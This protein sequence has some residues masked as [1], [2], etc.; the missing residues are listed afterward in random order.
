MRK[1]AS[2]SRVQMTQVSR[3]AL[4]AAKRIN[5]QHRLILSGTPIQNNILELWALFDFLMPGFL[6]T[7][8]AFNARYGKALAAAKGSKTGSPEAQAGLLAMESLHKQARHLFK[9]NTSDGQR[10]PERPLRVGYRI[11]EESDGANDAA[12]AE[13]NQRQGAQ[14]IRA[15]RMP[16]FCVLCCLVTCMR[17][18]KL[19]RCKVHDDQGCRTSTSVKVILIVQVMPFVLR[20]T[21]DQVL[22]DLPPKIIQDVYVEP[23]A[24]QRQLYEDFSSTSASQQA[25]SAVSGDISA[26]SAASKAPHVF[27]V[28]AEKHPPSCSQDGILHRLCRFEAHNPP[29]CG[30]EAVQPCVVHCRHCS[31]CASCAVTPYW[32]WTPQCRSMQLQ[33]QRPACRRARPTGLARA[34]RC[35]PCSTHPSCRRWHS[36]CRWASRLGWTRKGPFGHGAFILSPHATIPCRALSES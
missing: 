27:Q 30:K 13:E 22:K 31:T 33:W 9:D 35:G 36:Y 3:G 2:S 12:C 7:H 17:R 5:A 1:P 29:C 20:R 28:S 6:G 26:E 25:A 24:L 23:S 15:R 10:L 16:M 18:P 11:P 32:S 34:A 4:Q 21:K 19:Q 8:A 14:R